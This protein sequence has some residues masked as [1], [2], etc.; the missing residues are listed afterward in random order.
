MYGNLPSGLGGSTSSPA[1]TPIKFDPEMII[2]LAPSTGRPS[3]ALLVEEYDELLANFNLYVNRGQLGLRDQAA[4]DNLFQ[5]TAG[6][7]SPML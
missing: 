7:V 4:K 1:T 3:L 6:Q 2:T 5:V